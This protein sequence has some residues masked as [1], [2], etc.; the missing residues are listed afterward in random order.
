MPIMIMQ[1]HCNGHDSTQW[2]PRKPEG[3]KH[4]YMEHTASAVAAQGKQLLSPPTKTFGM[5]GASMVWCGAQVGKGK[6]VKVSGI[7]EQGRTAT[8]LLRGSN[9]LVL[10]EAERSLHDALCAPVSLCRRM[11]SSMLYMSIWLCKCAAGV[12]G[13]FCVPA[14]PVVLRAEAARVASAQCCDDVA[15]IPSLAKGAP[16]NKC[17]VPLCWH[18]D[19][20]K[21]EV[22]PVVAQVRDPVPGAEALPHSGRRGA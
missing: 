13:V 1:H 3:A 17:R 19:K 22:A 10:E 11:T 4:L 8:V 9:K 12:A 7:R 20:S 16:G 6:V 21:N 14:V 5:H 15:Q 18:Q 2:S